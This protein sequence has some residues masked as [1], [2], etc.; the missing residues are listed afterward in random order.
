MNQADALRLI[1]AR[2]AITTGAAKQQREAA[3]L[4]LA[5]VGAVCGVNQS[6]VWRWENGHRAPRGQT[7][8]RY[9][10]FLE[11]LASRAVAS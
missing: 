8:L 9:A 4:S 7:A 3:R 10:R 5:E 6:T 2:E 11:M 1:R